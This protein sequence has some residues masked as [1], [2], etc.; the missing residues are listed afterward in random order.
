M[1]WKKSDARHTAGMQRTADACLLVS[2]IKSVIQ[3]SFGTR[4]SVNVLVAR[5]SNVHDGTNG[6]VIHADVG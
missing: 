5:P 4:A 1:W 2:L 6:I 3:G